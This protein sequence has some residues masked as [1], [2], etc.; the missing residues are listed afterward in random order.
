MYN[1]NESEQKLAGELVKLGLPI[2]NKGFNYIVAGAIL[3]NKG[4]DVKSTWI[5]NKIAKDYNC[6]SHSVERAIRHEI[7]VYY[8]K[9]TNIPALLTPDPFSGIVTNKEFLY[10]LSYMFK[11]ILKDN[12]DKS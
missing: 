3:V 8:N 6:T 10:R 4:D 1:Y 12:T 7:M 9:N 11:D 2:S 5:Y